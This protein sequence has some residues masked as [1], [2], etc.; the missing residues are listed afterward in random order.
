MRRTYRERF[1]IERNGLTIRGTRY[2]EPVRHKPAVILSHGFMANSSMCGKY[3]G[4]LAEMGYLAFIFDF[5][6]GC[7]I[8]RSSGKTTD[9]SVL[10]EKD[11][12]DAVIR[13]VSSL[14]YV[15]NDRISLLGC[16]QGGFVSAMAAA[17]A[18]ERIASLVLLYP[19]FCIPDDARKGRMMFAKFDPA[20]VPEK[21]RCGPMRLGAGYV[22]AVQDMDPC[23]AIRGYTGPVLYL[24]GTADKIVDIAYARRAKQEYPDC[25]YHEIDGGGHMFRGKYDRIAQDYIKAFFESK[26]AH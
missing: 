15:D 8:G 5:C 23:A 7:L 9:M 24:H 18:P 12:L 25:E 21:L 13:Y 20:N 16:S 6:G 17:D 4:L 26:D 3:A 14:P 2:G 11:D 1:E 22:K 10:T 19:A